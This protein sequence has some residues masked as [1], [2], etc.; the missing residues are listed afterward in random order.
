MACHSVVTG[1]EILL[2]VDLLPSLLALCV[3]IEDDIDC[4][5]DFLHLKMY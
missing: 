4:P 2:V 1:D 3:I 5:F